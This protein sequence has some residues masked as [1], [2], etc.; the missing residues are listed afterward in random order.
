MEQ[1]FVKT[2]RY[3]KIFSI[4]KHFCFWDYPNLSSYILCI[5]SETVEKLVCK[6]VVQQ[7]FGHV[8]CSIS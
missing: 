7:H 6:T 3:F 8:V 5:F 2:L 4:E 1:I